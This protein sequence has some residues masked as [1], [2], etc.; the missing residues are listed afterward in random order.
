MKSQADPLVD[1]GQF[2][3]QITQLGLPE[4]NDRQIILPA[5]VQIGEQ[6]QLI[7]CGRRHFLRFVEDQNEMAILC[8][9]LF[10]GAAKSFATRKFILSLALRV[11]KVEGCADQILKAER[12]VFLSDDLEFLPV[13]L[14]GKNGA[15]QRFAATDFTGQHA[16]VHGLFG[17]EKAQAIERF[18][19]VAA[20][21]KEA[22][23]PRRFEGAF[24]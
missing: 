21:K 1:G 24:P 12:R 17:D 6:L 2:R 22:R 10:C 19:V 14:L 13:K 18:V 15:G 23:V 20:L 5:T 11:Q 9:D 7:H 16:D 8:M 4:Q 3:D